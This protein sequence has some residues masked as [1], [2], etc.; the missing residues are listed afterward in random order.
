VTEDEEDGDLEAE[1]E[2][3]EAEPDAAWLF[4]GEF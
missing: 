4:E 2:E 3:G 1:W